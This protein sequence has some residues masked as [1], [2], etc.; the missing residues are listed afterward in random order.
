M[1]K[2]FL[3]EKDAEISDLYLKEYAELRSKQKSKQVIIGMGYENV[4]YYP[5]D[6]FFYKG[7][8][9]SSDLRFI[10]YNNKDLAALLK[11]HKN[12]FRHYDSKNKLFYGMYLF[13]SRIIDTEA[14]QHCFVFETAKGEKISLK[15]PQGDKVDQPHYKA[16]SKILHLFRRKSVFYIEEDKILYIR[17]P[18][19]EYKDINFFTSKIIRK[20]KGKEI[21]AVVIDVRHNP[22]GRDSLWHSVLAALISQELSYKETYALRDVPQAKRLISNYKD[23]HQ[24]DIKQFT[25]KIV[26]Y[27]GNEKFL[28]KDSN[29]PIIPAE[30]SIKF[31]GPIYLLCQNI[32]SSTS[33]LASAAKSIDSIISIGPKNPNETGAGFDCVFFSLPNSKIILRFSATVDLANCEKLSDIMHADFEVEIPD[34]NFFRHFYREIENAPENLSNRRKAFWYLRNKDQHYKKVIELMS[35]KNDKIQ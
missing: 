18:V 19:M 6:S 2:G 13:S 35:E 31:K 29:L 4:N 5:V 12:Q 11:E 28:V 16:K 26:P 3:K 21:T 9:Y 27:L 32:F 34:Y 25:S 17:I 15:I 24:L 1:Y 7:K 10:S 33:N 8:K 30:N 20:S 22:G 14:K 23:T